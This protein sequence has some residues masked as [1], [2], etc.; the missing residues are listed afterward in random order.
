[1]DD[2]IAARLQMAISLGFHIVFACI[3]MTMPWLMAAAQWRWLRTREPVY[4]QLARAW[5]KGVAVFFAVGAVS[6][7]VLSFELGLLWP[8]FM[9]HAGPIIGLPFSW[10]GTAFFV[11]AIAIGIF[12]YGFERVPERIHFASGVVVGLSGLASG[13][14]VVAA[15]S[16]MNNP[17]GFRWE[18]GRAVDVDPVAAMFNA[19]WFQQSLHMVLAAFV[20]TAFA[21][22]GVHALRLLRKPDSR[23]HRIAMRIALAMGAVAALLQPLSGDVSAKHVAK[24]QPVKLAALEAH[25]H[26]ERGAS[27]VVGG[28]PDDAARR[29]RYAIEIPYLLSFLAFGDPHAEVMGLDRV[30][31]EDW[32]PTVICHWAFQIMI[33]IGSALAALG[34]CFLGI[35]RWR[36]KL[37]EDPRI[38]KLIAACTPLGFLAVEAGWTVTEVGRQPWIIY[39]VLRTRDA[40]TPMPGLIW[41]LLTMLAVY[42]ILS[43]LIAWIMTHLIRA[44]EA[45]EDAAHG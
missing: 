33:G 24:H 15:N 12:L 6:G 26:T 34:G 43:A 18:N 7:T 40:V 17:R 4:L 2:L 3:G 27:F 16:W 22:A 20:S 23:L 10:E 19:G 37:L 32:P 30:P 21:V 5:S 14:L 25:Y 8:E 13:I 39:G 35:W 42:L 1:M 11:E 31:R 41:P 9:E 38:L 45:T 28:L 29:V 44:A 36:P